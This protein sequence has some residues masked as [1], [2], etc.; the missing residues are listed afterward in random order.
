MDI[1]DGNDFVDGG[2]LR[3]GKLV[4]VDFSKYVENEGSVPRKLIHR[5][6]CESYIIQ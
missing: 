2:D 3:Y 4:V 1:L 5:K 6:S